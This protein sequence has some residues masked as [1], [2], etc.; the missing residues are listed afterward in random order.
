MN[1]KSLII[2]FLVIVAVISSAFVLSSCFTTIGLVSCKKSC[3]ESCKSSTEDNISGHEYGVYYELSADGE[4][5]LVSEVGYS[6]TSV[7]IPESYEGK[8]VTG[9][10]SGA[11]S[12][13]VYGSGCSGTYTFGMTLSSLTLPSTIKTVESGAFTS[14]DGYYV[15]VDLHYGL[16]ARCG[17]LI[18]KGTLEDWFGMDFGSSAFS[19]DTEL[20]INGAK[21]TDLVIPETVTKI[22]KYAFAY[23]GGLKS[24]TLHEKITVIEDGA[25]FN[26]QGLEEI[27]FPCT[28]VSVGNSAFAECEQLKKVTFTGAKAVLEDGVFSGCVNLKEVEWN[29]VNITVIPSYAFSACIGL[30]SF[31]IPASVEVIKPDAFNGCYGLLEVYNLSKLN[32][33]A[34]ATTHGGVAKYAGVVHTAEEDNSTIMTVGDYKF[35]V[36]EE[37]T[38]LFK[39]TGEGEVLFLPELESGK[40]YDIRANT[41]SLNHTITTVIIPDCVTAIG[42][43]AFY[44]CDNLQLVSGCAGVVTLGSGAFSECVRLAS[45]VLGK[46]EEIGDEAFDSCVALKSLELPETLTKIGKYAFCNCEGLTSITLPKSLTEIGNDAFIFCDAEIKYAGT[47]EEWN[48]VKRAENGVAV[49]VTCSDGVWEGKI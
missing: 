30:T 5:Y 33:V 26:C 47:L 43:N 31:V 20:Y 18:Y 15:T 34:G 14:D 38:T 25:F 7:I 3:Q 19:Y 32:V 17:K 11:F 12:H 39:Y 41:F 49:T 29:A 44:Y 40:T 8:P 21:V 1:K 22:N 28:D 6:E 45:I 36:S 46:V 27:S 24:V 4:S 9:I 48:K 35:V 37:K 23:Y 42:E 16:G 10:K 13:A 2:K